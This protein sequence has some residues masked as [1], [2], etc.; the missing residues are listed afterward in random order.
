MIVLFNEEDLISFGEYV[1]SEER[2]N[3]YEG[4]V[5]IVTG[6]DLELWAAKKSNNE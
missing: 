3:Q 6:K 2:S 5:N 1:L 4:D